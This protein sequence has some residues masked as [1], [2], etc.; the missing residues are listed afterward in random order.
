MR[1]KYK[2]ELMILLL[3]VY[4]KNLK[5]EEKGKKFQ[6]I[7]SICDVLYGEEQIPSV[8]SWNTKLSNLKNIHQK[9]SNSNYAPRDQVLF[10]TY[11]NDRKSLDLK[12]AEIRGEYLYRMGLEKEFWTDIEQAKKN[13]FNARERILKEISVRRGQQS[14]RKRL[15]DV[16]ERRCAVTGSKTE[17][18][19][20]AA[21]ILPF[22]ESANNNL[23]NGIILRADIH[24]LFDKNLMRI[25]ED[26]VISVDGVLEGTEYT[27]YAGKKI[28]L[29][30]SKQQLPSR[31]MLR[32]KYANL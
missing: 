29:P 19:L 2:T 26:Y 11:V 12:V 20:E 10:D 17:A 21:H 32:L 5:K 8:R 24:V 22:S 23:N 28:H 25:S 14:F 4:L 9:N 15:L 16:Y 30:K 18:V 1:A 3:D 7:K 31:E 27:K 6:E 13:L